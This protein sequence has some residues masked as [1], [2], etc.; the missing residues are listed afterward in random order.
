MYWLETIELRVTDW[1]KLEQTLGEIA[2][3]G[4]DEREKINM[5][6]YRHATVEN[7]I[8]IMLHG[9]TEGE[10]QQGRDAGRY[11]V[12]LLK[13]MALVSQDFWLEYG[14]ST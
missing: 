8:L 10:M 4:I 9:N 3:K 1:C 6:I 14:E 12:H 13:P 7:N 5:K 11:L 2:A